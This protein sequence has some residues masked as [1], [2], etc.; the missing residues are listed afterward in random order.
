MVPEEWPSRIV[1]RKQGDALQNPAY[2]PADMLKRGVRRNAPD[3]SPF[4][5]RFYWVFGVR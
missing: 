2:R 1:S 5:V 3:P 4:Y